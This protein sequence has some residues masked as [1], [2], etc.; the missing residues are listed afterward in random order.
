MWINQNACLKQNIK[1]KIVFVQDIQKRLHASFF[2]KNLRLTQKE[3]NL[4][5]HLLYFCFC[6]HFVLENTSD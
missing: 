1:L 2:M 3:A 6:L 4:K 5:A